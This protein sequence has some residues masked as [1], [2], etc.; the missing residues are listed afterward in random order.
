MD[1]FGDWLYYII[2]L[3]VAIVS[4]ANSAKKKNRSETAEPPPA[5]EQ[6]P[7]VHMP[8]PRART[9]APPPVPKQAK[10]YVPLFQNEGQRVLEN[11]VSFPAEKENETSLAEKLELK[12]ADAF[13][14]AV[15]YAEILNRKY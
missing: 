15:I 5:Y 8:P 7:P 1:N 9:K 10:G 3:V 13:R 2:F 4:F 6:T 14:K 12:N 11:A